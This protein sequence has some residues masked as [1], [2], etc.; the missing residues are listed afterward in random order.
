MENYRAGPE[1]S[2]DEEDIRGVSLPGLASKVS[3]QS[4]MCFTDLFPLE[5]TLL[6]VP[7]AV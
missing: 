1:I 7:R 3:T 4:K 2:K 6:H 5:N